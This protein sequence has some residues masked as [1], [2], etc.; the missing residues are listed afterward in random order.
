MGQL[1]LQNISVDYTNEKVMVYYQNT[2]FDVP[3]FAQLTTLKAE[4]ETAYKLVFDSVSVQLTQEQHLSEPRIV[5]VESENLNVHIK[6]L[7]EVATTTPELY[8]EIQAARVEIENE[9]RN[10]LEQ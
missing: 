5:L 2:L 6:T 10:Q 4:F 7:V 3:Y 8:T 9:I 1:D